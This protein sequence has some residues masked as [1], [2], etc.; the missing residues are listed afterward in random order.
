MFEQAEVV[1]V[2]PDHPSLSGS[3]QDFL[4]E[5]RRESRFFGPSSATNP[6]P[7]SSLIDGLDIAADGFRL[8]ALESGRIVGMTRISEAGMVLVAVVA[9]ARGRGVG[10]ALMRAGIE[11]SQNFGFARLSLRSS[12]RSR[13]ARALATSTGCLAVDHGRGRVELI[14]DLRAAPHSA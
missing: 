12:R 9:D 11:R 14:L 13:A 4:S 7:F 2:T 6:K 5:L 3:V 10:T 1:I 8:A